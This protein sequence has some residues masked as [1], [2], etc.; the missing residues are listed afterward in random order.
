MK[1]LLIL[2][3][4]IISAR[5]HAIEPTVTVPWQAFDKLYQG[6]IKQA[7]KR[8]DIPEPEPVIVLEQVQ[9]DLKIVNAQAIGSISIVGS[10]LSGEPDPL[11]LFGQ[12]VAVTNILETQNATLIASLGQYQLYTYEPGLFSIKLEVSIPISDF[13]VKPKLAFDVPQAVRNELKI[14]SSQNLKLLP[15]HVLHD[16][17]GSYFFPPTSLLSIGFEH[18]NRSVD[19]L[20]SGDSLLSEVETPDAVLDSVTF[21]TSFA[22]DGA[23]LTAMHLLLPVSEKSQLELNPIEGAEVWSLRVNDQPRRLYESAA[24]MWVIPLDVNVKSK[25]EL[26]YLTRGQKLGLEGRLEFSI[27]ETGLTAQR[28]NLSVGLPDR[29]HMLALDSDLQATNGQGW[30]TFNSFSGRP[31]FFSKPFYRGHSLTASIIYQEPV[32]P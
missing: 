18:I 3:V 27:P 22:E 9:Y 26:A 25:V 5:V 11:S 30:P 20:V 28:V 32:N 10:V 2:I 6:Q 13:Q 17:N 24:G 23:V 8:Q 16:I 31:H 7:L 4:L 12:N 29:M 21:F 1:Q 14:Q 15:N 19:G